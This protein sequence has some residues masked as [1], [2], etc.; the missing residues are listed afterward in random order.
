MSCWENKE[1][2]AFF[3]MNKTR[4]EKTLPTVSPLFILRFFFINK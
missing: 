2:A 3:K 4:L 1:V